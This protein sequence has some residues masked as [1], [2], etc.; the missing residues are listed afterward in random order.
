MREH[1]RS[2]PAIGSSRRCERRS[3]VGRRTN[4]Y[5][6]PRVSYI[7]V[8]FPPCRSL[9]LFPDPPISYFL[10][11]LRRIFNAIDISLENERRW[12]D[13]VLI[14][15]VN[16]LAFRV[17]VSVCVNASAFIKIHR[18]PLILENSL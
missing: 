16:L 8:P 9:S 14:V 18:R 11:Y 6:N 17:Y 2:P 12:M 7:I 13:T 1:L 5:L 3:L 4:N 15:S 10:S